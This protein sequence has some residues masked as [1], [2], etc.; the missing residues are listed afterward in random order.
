MK[1]VIL[2][3]LACSLGFSSCSDADKT[4]QEMIDQDLK[5]LKESLNTEKVIGYKFCK[6]MMRASADKTSKHHGAFKNQLEDNMKRLM[7]LDQ[8][9]HLSVSEYLKMYSDYAQMRDYIVK[10]D[11][12]VFPTFLESSSSFYGSGRKKKQLQGKAKLKQEAYEHAVLSAV[13]MLSRDLGKEVALYECSEID[14]EQLEDSEFKSLILFYRGFLFCEK[15]LYYLSERDLTANI[16]WLEKDTKTDLKWVRFFFGWKKQQNKQARTGFLSMNYLFRGLDRA[17]GERDIDHER[18][19]EDFEHF[20]K[21]SKEMGVSSELTLSIE[22][23]VALKKGENDRAIMALTKLKDSPKLS[24]AEKN[25][26]EESITHLQND[27]ADEVLDELYDKLFL[28]K[29]ASNYMVEKTASIDWQTFLRKQHVPNSRKMMGT[30][31]TFKSVVSAIERHASGESI[32]E[33]GESLWDEAKGL[34]E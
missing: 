18:S 11:E 9:K 31:T 28:A 5:T 8:S 13:V 24:D 34:M 21:L 19:L 25:V 3:L 7:K 17:L 27:E 2:F 26:I 20:L 4:D 10:T 1:H 30:V 29:I 12:D 15:G 16:E 14:P 6:L 33:E 23:Y 22:A 32:K